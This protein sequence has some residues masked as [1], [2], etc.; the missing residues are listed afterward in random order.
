[1]AEKPEFK[2]REELR[3]LLKL[4]PDMILEKMLEED[5]PLN[6]QYYLDL[7]WPDGMTWED[8]SGEHR[9]MLMPYLVQDEDGF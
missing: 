3:R 9:G 2:D 5:L 8:L 7:N 1:M 6:V 4:L